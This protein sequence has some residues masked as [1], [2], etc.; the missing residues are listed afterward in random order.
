MIRRS[1][2]NARTMAQRNP[3]NVLIQRENVEQILRDYGVTEHIRD[4]S[5]YQTAM[6]HK[7]YLKTAQQP[8][9]I[10]PSDDEDGSLEPM[11]QS[12]ERLEF[13]GDTV[14]GSAIGT[15]LY[16][17]YPNQDEGF[18]TKLKTKL[19]RDTTCA[20]LCRIL[21]LQKFI[22]LSQ[23]LDQVQN[24]RDNEKFQEDVFEAFLGAMYVDFGG[25][26]LGQSGHAIDLC[27]S[28]I[29]KLYETHI[30]F[31]ALIHHDDN[32]KDQLLRYFQRN[33]GGQHPKY[34]IISE[35]GPTN[36]R[37]YEMGVMD[38]HGNIIGCGRATK[39]IQAEQ[40]ASMKALE[41]LGAPLN[42]SL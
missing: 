35:H 27:H 32:F 25:L 15:Y 16:A 36:H 19:V 17:R 2:K 9:T 3:N 6:V 38:I 37:V 5:L 8:G 39:K 23:Y 18:M 21:G 40:M 30:N 41:H 28:F 33:F 12:Y 1:N 4:I 14:L 26:N 29:I 22:I 11:D 13:I 24:S 10:K 31:P 7:S 20:E 34:Q 42:E